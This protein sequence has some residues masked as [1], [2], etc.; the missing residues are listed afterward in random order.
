MER[1][2]V[3]PEG[4][5]GCVLTRAGFSIPMGTT[6]SSQQQEPFLS[7]TSFH[8]PLS[9]LGWSEGTWGRGE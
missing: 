1:G 8:C 5:A 9:E 2:R 4:R 3:S 6:D 7:G